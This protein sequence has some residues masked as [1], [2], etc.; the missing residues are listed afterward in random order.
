[1]TVYVK[2]EF[3]KQTSDVWLTEILE[4]FPRVF[5]LRKS[6]IKEN[7]GKETLLIRDL[8]QEL[9]ETVGSE[10]LLLY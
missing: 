3:D 1:M 4:T 6:R 2:L 5:L 8:Q 7:G 10:K 9:N